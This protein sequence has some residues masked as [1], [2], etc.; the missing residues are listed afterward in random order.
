MPTAEAEQVDREAASALVRYRELLG[1]CKHDL[2]LTHD[3]ALAGKVPFARLQRIKRAQRE[4][5]DELREFR[6]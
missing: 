3:A 1:R 6:K 4:V 2:K 5:E